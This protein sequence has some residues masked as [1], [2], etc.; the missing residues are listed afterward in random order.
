MFENYKQQ[1]KFYS[2]AVLWPERNTMDVNKYKS[3]TIKIATWRKLHKMA[4]KDVRSVSRTIEYLVEK[5]SKGG[6][7]SK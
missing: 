6:G 3:V 4:E 2:N 7:K 1:V 5:Y